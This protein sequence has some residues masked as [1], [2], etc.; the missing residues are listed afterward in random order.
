MLKGGHSD[1]FQKN[2]K[3]KREKEKKKKEK[4][5]EGDLINISF[6]D[7]SQNVEPNFTF[8]AFSIFCRSMLVTIMNQISVSRVLYFSYVKV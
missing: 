8:R 3:R 1:F 5:K 6:E 2:Y 4:E 7:K